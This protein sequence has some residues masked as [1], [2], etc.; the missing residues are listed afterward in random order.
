M[1]KKQYTI[2]RA[3]QID[4]FDN[5]RIPYKDD[6]SVLVD[7]TDGVYH[8]NILEFKLNINNT[9]KVLFQAIKYLSKM[10]IKGE[11]VP[12]RILLIDLNAT[13]V[14][15]YNSKDYLDDIQKI[16][17]GAASVGNTDFSSNVMPVAVFDYMDMVDSAAVQKLLINKVSDESEWYVPIDLDE[18]C[19]VGWAERYY[20]E[21]PTATKG[22]FLGDGTGKINVSGEIREPRHFKG[23][24]NPYQEQTNEKFKYLMDCLNDR[25]NKKDLG[26]F[27]TPAPYCEKASELVMKAVERVP[28]GND[29]IILDRASGTGNLE[30]ALIGKYDKNGDELISHCVASTYEYYEY[31]VLQERIGDKVRN[32]IPPTEANVVYENGKISNADAMSKDFIENPLIKQYV[33]DEKCTIILYENPPYQDSSAITYVDD[34]GVRGQTGRKDTYVCSQYKKILPTLNE[35]KGSFREISNLFI[36]SG[37]EYYLR[38]DTDSYV[39]FSPIKYW[40]TI[41]LAEHKYLTGYVFNRKY[42]HATSS[43]ISCILWSSEPDTV[44]SLSLEILDIDSNDNLLSIG[45]TDVKKVHSTYANLYDKRKFDDDVKSET[46]CGRDGELDVTHKRDGQSVDNDNILAYVRTINYSPDAMNRIM[47]RQMYFG[48]RGYYLRKD[49]YLDK[50]PLF[51]SKCVPFDEWYE[52]DLYY[53]SADGGDA[54]THDENFLKSCLIYTC[55]SNQNKCLSFT[56]SDGRYYRNE[57][58]FDTTNGDTVASV[59]LARMSLDDEEKE[60]LKLW[61]DILEEAKKTKEYKKELT[62]GVYQIT[63][64]LNT[65]RKIGSGKSKKTIYDYPILNG[66]LEALRINLKK[67]Y[68]SHITEKMFKYELLK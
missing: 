60:L 37:F 56:G 5:Y 10:R 32:I 61:K 9:G 67:Y 35:G 28:E 24:I 33:D 4:F 55:L 62:Y 26:A 15:V 25:L 52:K 16:Y 54:Y 43:T 64:E 59:D 65:S 31:K 36:W 21:V 20:R 50:L 41:G 53:N 14:Y 68:K 49:N 40:K 8:G 58:C 46:Y 29:Y 11:S 27:Y 1:A 47:I 12:A 63:K 51:V 34:K 18:N 6:A 38:Q 44:D 2:E 57:L 42:F 13:K 17:V 22:D 7:N 39:L 45:K 19:I 3:G 48:A 23:L 66:Y 30:A